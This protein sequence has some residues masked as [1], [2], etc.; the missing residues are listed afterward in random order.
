MLKTLHGK[1]SLC[2]LALLCGVGLLLI[3][4]SAAMTRGY[5]REVN[6]N[7][8][9]GLALYMARSLS[10]A[11]LLPTDLKTNADAQKRTSAEIS[12]LMVLNPDIEIYVLD[13]NGSII[14]YSSAPGRVQS[15]RVALGPVR[16]FESG[17][18]MLPILGD[19]PRHLDAQK[20]FSAATIPALRH[21]PPKKY[22]HPA[23][24]AAKF[25]CV[26]QIP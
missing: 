21:S 26:F 22:S 25:E 5:V 18:A 2:L 24:V 7:L 20:T 13:Q 11:R 16:R 9:Q 23:R 1:L 8:N 15:K 17:R 12:H 19:D 6:Q 14:A 3:P 10:Q 4:L